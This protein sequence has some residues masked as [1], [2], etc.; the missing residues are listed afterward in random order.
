MNADKTDDNK[1]VF[2]SVLSFIMQNKKIATEKTT[3]KAMI[4]IYCKANHKGQFMCEE[5]SKLID[6]A[7]LRL[8]KC[9]YNEN[10]PSCKKCKTHC[11]NTENRNRIRKIMR[12]SGKRMIFYNPILSLRHLLKK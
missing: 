5:C 10:K 3:V 11:Y 1:S 8:D 2:V 4:E 7:F 9:K 12:F 6:Y